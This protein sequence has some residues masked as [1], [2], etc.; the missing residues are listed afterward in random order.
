MLSLRQLMPSETYGVRGSLPVSPSPLLGSDQNATRQP[1]G[2]I[3]SIIERRSPARPT[4]RLPGQEVPGFRRTV[5]RGTSSSQKRRRCT[6]LLRRCLLAPRRTLPL[7]LPQAPIAA[8]VALPSAVRSVHC[9]QSVSQSSNKKNRLLPTTE[10]M[11]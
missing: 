8:C 9:G 1:M 4:I 2:M 6:R 11:N 7:S 3:Q 5:G 10:E